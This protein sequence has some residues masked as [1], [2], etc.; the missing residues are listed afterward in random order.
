MRGRRA[1]LASPWRSLLRALWPLLALACSG[2][3]LFGSAEPVEDLEQVQVVSPDTPFDP[4][5]AVDDDDEAGAGPLAGK[6]SGDRAEP[7]A[8]PEPLTGSGDDGGEHIATPEEVQQLKQERQRALEQANEEGSDR[9][10]KVELAHNPPAEQLG[11]AEPVGWSIADYAL[12][13][14]LVAIAALLVSGGVQLLKTFP[15]AAGLPVLGACALLAVWV[16][17]QLA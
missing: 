8:A 16:I 1:L 13:S 11:R 2:C 9:E 5:Q 15:R 17:A 14:L 10:A 3:G 12:E 7:T 6:Q 4:R